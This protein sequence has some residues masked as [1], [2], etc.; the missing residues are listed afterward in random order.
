MFPVRVHLEKALIVDAGK[1]WVRGG[2]SIGGDA[3]E[4]KAKVRVWGGKSC[5]I[6]RVSEAVTAFLMMTYGGSK[7][8][9]I[10]RCGY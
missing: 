8:H 9:S 10:I 7:H 4:T 3:R 2:V 5:L 6:P 1:H